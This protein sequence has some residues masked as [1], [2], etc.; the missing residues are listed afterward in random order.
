MGGMADS[1]HWHWPDYNMN[2][3]LNGYDYDNNGDDDKI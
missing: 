1:G 2:M 3:M